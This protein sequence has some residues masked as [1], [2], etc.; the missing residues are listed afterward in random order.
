MLDKIENIT[1]KYLD[2]ELYEVLEANGE[3][4]ILL[5]DLFDK[6]A[7]FLSDCESIRDELAETSIIKDY[8]VLDDEKVLIIAQ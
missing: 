2:V 5:Y 7:N 4:S 3:F 8:Q 1:K 6:G